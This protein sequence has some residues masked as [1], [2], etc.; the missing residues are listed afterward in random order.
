MHLIYENTSLKHF[1]YIDCSVAY[2]QESISYR[3]L[4]CSCLTSGEVDLTRGL[5]TCIET[6]QPWKQDL[7]TAMLIA[8][9]S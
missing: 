2:M 6:R 3:H 1:V 4:Y 7:S 8:E 5:R 9:L